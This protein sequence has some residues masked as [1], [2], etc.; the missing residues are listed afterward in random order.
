MR[1]AIERDGYTVNVILAESAAVADLIAAQQNGTAYALAE[2][3]H[4]RL[5]VPVDSIL[6]PSGLVCSPRQARLALAQ[7]NLLDAVDAF[8]QA[9]DAALKIEWEYATEI[10]RDWPPVAAF[11]AANGIDDA[12]IDGLFE[13]AMTL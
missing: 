1:Y 4:P 9:G 11:A 8:V 3:E 5:P 12:T 7:S 13:L 2:N 6:V 10:S